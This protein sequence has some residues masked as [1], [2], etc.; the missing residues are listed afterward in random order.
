MG[1]IRVGV[2]GM[3][4]MGEAH[5][6]IYQ[7]NEAVELVGCVETFEQ[8]RMQIAQMLD[9]PVYVTMD[10]LLDRGVDAVSICT[11]DNMHRDFVVKA[12]A[13]NVKVLVEKPFDI[14]TAACNAMLKARPDPTYLMVGHDLR[15]DTRLIQAKR[16]YASGK[17]GKLLYVNTRRCNSL[18][19]CRRIGSR[20]SIVWFLGIH[21]IDAALWVTGLAIEEIISVAG[22]KYYNDTWDC[23][24]AAIRL[25]GGT[26]LQLDTHWIHQ[27]GSITGCDAWFKMIGNKGSID[28][29]LLPHEGA[30][31]Y[32]DKGA[33]YFDTHYQPDD[34]FGIPSG[35]L[36]YQLEHFI[37]CVRYNKIPLTTGEQATEAVRVIEEIEKR[38][39]MTGYRIRD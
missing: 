14:S 19:S 15:F 5:A 1:R 38:L 6:K 12:F 21:D 22:F 13:R 20:A 24:T 2:V 33:G 34:L 39:E 10:E 31:T 36:R 25:E 11:P 3:G 16:A 29:N 27:D 4:I 7:N 17:L 9:V 35:D 28:L 26:L 30:Y 32:I 23:V 8:R 18:A 37:D